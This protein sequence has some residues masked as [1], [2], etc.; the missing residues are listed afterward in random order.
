L[1]FANVT[2]ALIVT[3]STILVDRPTMRSIEYLG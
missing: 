1:E 2:S 3:R